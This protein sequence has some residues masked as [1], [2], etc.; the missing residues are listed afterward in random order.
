VLRVRGRLVVVGT[1]DEI[2]ALGTHH[3]EGAGE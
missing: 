2:D 3:T 1:G